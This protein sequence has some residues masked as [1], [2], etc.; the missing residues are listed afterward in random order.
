M[1]AVID[2]GE[3]GPQPRNYCSVVVAG[4]CLRSRDCARYRYIQAVVQSDDDKLS[5]R[6][7]QTF[8]PSAEATGDPGLHH[9]RAA[10]GG[11]EVERASPP[12]KS[13]E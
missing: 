3:G 7:G 1:R 2:A 8:D 13:L 6:I 4:L 11:R 10:L 9:D 5:P 12:T